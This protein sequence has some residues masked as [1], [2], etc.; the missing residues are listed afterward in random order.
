M[1]GI[2]DSYSPIHEETRIF[3]GERL[4]IVGI[5]HS[6]TPYT[7]VAVRQGQRTQAPHRNEM[8]KDV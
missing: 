3:I 6:A 2:V 5:C 1:L 8:R 7:L 4:I